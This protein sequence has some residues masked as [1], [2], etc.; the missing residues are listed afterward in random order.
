LLMDQ[1]DALTLRGEVVHRGTPDT[2]GVEFRDLSP[3]EQYG[4]QGL[5]ARLHG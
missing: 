4:V 5:I 3:A 1:E 2:F